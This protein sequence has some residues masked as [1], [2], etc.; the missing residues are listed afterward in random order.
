MGNSCVSGGL[1]FAQST[2]TCLKVTTETQWR[3]ADVVIVNFEDISNLVIV[4][5]L[6]TLRA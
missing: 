5:L 1:T 6:L 2:I 3:C 4:F